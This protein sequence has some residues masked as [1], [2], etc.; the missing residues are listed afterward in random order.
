LVLQATG[1]QPLND[2]AIKEKKNILFMVLLLFVSVDDFDL[3]ISL[4]I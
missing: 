3:S 1:H 2:Q 4:K